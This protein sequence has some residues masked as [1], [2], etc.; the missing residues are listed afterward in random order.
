VEEFSVTVGIRGGDIPGECILARMSAW[1]ERRCEACC[2]SLERGDAENRL[3][4]QTVLRLRME[5]S[6]SDKG[7]NLALNY[8]IKKVSLC[9]H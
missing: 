8:E 7:M 9:K 4:L 3:H 5:S 6:G 1:A 2:M